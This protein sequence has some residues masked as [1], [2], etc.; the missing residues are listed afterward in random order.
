MKPDIALPAVRIAAVFLAAL[1][2]SCASVVPSR[3]C[4]QAQRL[5]AGLA[6]RGLFQGAFA[7]G[8]AGGPRCEGAYGMANVEAA[9]PYTLDTTNDGASIAKTMTAAAVLALAAEGKL[10]LEAPVQ[11]YLPRYPHAA[12]RVRHLISH[13]AALPGYDWFD[14]QLGEGKLRSN[15]LQLATVAQRGIPPAFAPGTRFEYDNAAFDMAAL[16]IEQASGLSYEAFLRARYFGPL[17]M[18]TAFVRPARLADFAGVRTRGYRRAEG[19]LALHDAIEGEAFHGGGNVYLSAR[20]LHAWVL[21]FAGDSPLVRAARRDA[22]ARTRL[23]DGRATGLSLPSWYS[24]AAARR[25]YYVGDHQGFYNFGYWDAGSGLAIAFVGNLVLSPW[26]KG[27]LPRALI[28]VAEGRAPESLDEPTANAAAGKTPIEGRWQVEG[29]GLVDIRREGNRRTLRAPSG[30]E[31][32]MYGVGGGWH[33]TPGLDGWIH[34]D[35]AEKLTWS[36]VFTLSSGH[37]T[38]P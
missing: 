6:A 31:Y 17:G 4:A 23:D 36:S 8:A 32:R 38:H 13:S 25:H 5:V 35:A 37:R 10:D 28:A 22:V 9:A 33:A 26:L 7:I 24:D 11:R 14:A 34:Y 3:D 21:A 2:V 12:T 29:V 18:S 27:A 20:D 16:V 1:Q 15:A 30:V 19:Q